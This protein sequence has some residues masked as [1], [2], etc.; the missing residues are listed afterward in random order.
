M[1]MTK[2]FLINPSMDVS[3]GFGEYDKLMEPMPCIGLAYLASSCQKAGH[4]VFVL[5][6]FTE[7]K[8]FKQIVE[9]IKSFGADVVGISML[10]PTANSTEALGRFIKA[11]LPSIKVIFGNLHASLF[12]K[13]LINNGACDAVVHGEGEIVSQG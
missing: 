7:N 11:Q 13:D 8:T 3:S 1:R 4:T 9:S 2:V 10:T 12:A 6:N 5:D